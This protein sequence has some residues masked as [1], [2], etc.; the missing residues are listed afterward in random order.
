M[1]KSVGTPRRSITPLALM[2]TCLG[3]IIGSGWL[4]GAYNTAKI[5]GPAAILAWVI[6]LVMMLAI[7]LTYTELGAMYPES[8]G[9]GRYTGY[10]HGPF[11]G[12]LASWAN[13][14]SMLVIPPIEAVASVQYMATWSF[15]WAQRLVEGGTLTPWGLTV[16]TLLLLLYLLLNYWT[17]AL[18]AKSNTAITLFKLV[19]PL[20]TAVC[21]LGLD[22]HPENFTAAG[23]FAPYG[24]AAILTGVATSGIVFSF[25]G[26]QSP[27][28]LAGEAQRPGRSVPLAVVGG[29]LLSGAIYLLLQIG[30]IGAVDPQSLQAGGWSGLRFESP[31]AE[32]AV[33]LGL[34]WLALTLYADAVIS[35]SGTG[36]TYV[37][38]SARAL[39]A[40]ARSGYLPDW[41]GR[42]HP[43]LG[44]PRNAMLCNLAISLLALFLFPNWEALAAVVSVTCVIG[45]LTGP[46]SVVSLR[47]TAPHARRP[48]TLPALGLLAPVAFVFA[49]LLVYWSRWPLNGQIMLLVLLGLP[50]YLTVQARRGWQDTASHLRSGAWL[51][52]Y[53][54]ALTLLSLLGSREFGGL[55]LLPYGADMAAVVGLALAFYAWGIRSGDPEAARHGLTATSTDPAAVPEALPG[56]SR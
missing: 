47:R 27:I 8:G 7:A 51:P 17:V 23:G 41:L 34:N 13:W 45:F 2:F 48:L 30:F 54:L 31:F 22:F 1:T 4:F 14:L 21:L 49:S 35:P 39:E 55:G 16:A 9:M 24:W 19:V 5:A 43:A 3:S 38:T 36:I 52:V 40:L 33:A 32:L 10:S 28:N 53:L 42:L 20:L 18:F 6:G 11:A 56:T 29:L 37:A 12:L 15:S 25:N 44:V 46:V 50:I 26:F